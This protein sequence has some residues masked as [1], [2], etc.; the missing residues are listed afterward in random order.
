MLPSK[1]EKKTPTALREYITKLD[2]RTLKKESRICRGKV[3][4]RRINNENSFLEWHEYVIAFIRMK[5]DHSCKRNFSATIGIIS[6]AYLFQMFGS[7][8]H[9][10]KTRQNILKFNSKRFKIDTSSWRFDF[11]HLYQ[12]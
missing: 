11:L 6:D 1:R 12:I 5:M 9:F 7:H 8:Y 4:R 3:H 2:L 10:K